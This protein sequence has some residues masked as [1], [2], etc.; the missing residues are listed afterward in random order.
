MKKLLILPLI[1]VVAGCGSQ[2]GATST[3]TSPPKTVVQTKTV[4]I[5]AAPEVQTVT[6]IKKV[7]V[8]NQAQVLACKMVIHYALASEKH[9][10]N[11][12][13]LYEH[14]IAP[15]YKAGLYGAS[16]SHITAKVKA[17]NDQVDTGTAAIKKA[18]GYADQCAG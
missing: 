5:P 15:A 13:V 12:A 3:V 11:A 10:L 9:L 17:G 7:K 14:Q 8:T 1:I 6:K 2:A 16:V 4:T 18:Q